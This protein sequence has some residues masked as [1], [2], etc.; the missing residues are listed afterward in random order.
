MNRFLEMKERGETILFSQLLEEIPP[1]DVLRELLSDP[2]N[3]KKQLITR[4]KLEVLKLRLDGLCQPEIAGRLGLTLGQV[5]YA[6]VAATN[7]LHG[8]IPPYIEVDIPPLRRLLGLKEREPTGYTLLSELLRDM[9]SDQALQDLFIERGNIVRA[10]G[11]TPPTN[12]DLQLLQMRSQKQSYDSIGETVGMSA[13][14]VRHQIALILRRIQRDLEIKIDVP[15]LYKPKNFSA[16][17]GRAQ[18][19]EFPP[20]SAKKNLNV[21]SKRQRE[22][23]VLHEQGLKRKEIAQRLC[24]TYGAVREHIIHAERR[25]REYERYCAVEE[26]NRGKGK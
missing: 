9:P 13:K 12:Q 20:D 14:E 26:K 5:A 8:R 18:A 15:D 10:N 1:E 17:T 25:F 6:S 24:I 21:L 23:W 7:Y 11:K 3:P 19:S 4:R 2:Q 16:Q 22:V